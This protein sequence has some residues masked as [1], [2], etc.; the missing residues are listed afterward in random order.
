MKLYLGYI[1]AILAAIFN[2]MIGVFSVKIM[3]L[4]LPPFAIAFYKCLISLA[5]L[6]AWLC[7]TNQFGQWI[8]HLKTNYFKIAICAFFGFFI[9]YFFETNAYSYSKV[10]VVVFF[11]LGSAT[12]TTFILSAILHKQKVRIYELFSCGLAL[13]GLSLVFGVYSAGNIHLEGLILAIIAGIGYGAFL[14]LSPFFQIGSGLIVVNSLLLF[15]TLYL[16]I[17]F[18]NTKL[19]YPTFSDMPLLLLLSLLPTIGGFWCTTKALTLLKS[20]TVQ[21]LELSEPI[22]AIIMAYFFLE[23][24][25]TI[26]EVIGG[27]FILS[28]IYVNYHGS[29]KSHAQ[30]I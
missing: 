16:F 11:L 20:N 22:F 15:G 12:L 26:F 3:H 21:L 6:T 23:Q 10:S 19:V 24:H 13:V 17:P 18:I 5:I 7:A 27:G 2:G 14:T 28:A 30:K 4:G 1:C 25:L 29:K 9:L 8:K